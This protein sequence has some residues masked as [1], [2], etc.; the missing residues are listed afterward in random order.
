MFLKKISSLD[1]KPTL[2][3]MAGSLDKIDEIDYTWDGFDQYNLIM[4]G[5]NEAH[6]DHIVF[7]VGLRN[8]NS[9]TIVF[10]YKNDNHL[11]KYIAQDASVDQW[12][13][14]REDGWCVP[15]DNGDWNVIY[16]DDISLAQHVDNKYL[17]DLTEDVS[18]K[19]LGYY[20]IKP[21]FI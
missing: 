21:W 4:H 1:W 3:H 5:K 2:L 15:D 17:F 9:A 19:T 11:Y 10:K 13:Y 20:E 7:N 16:N 6:R 14:K 8:L 18:E 12:A